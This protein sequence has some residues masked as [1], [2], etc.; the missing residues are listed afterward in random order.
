MSG[1]N[2]I[3]HSCGYSTVFQLLVRLS[4]FKDFFKDN[5]KSDQ[6]SKILNEFKFIF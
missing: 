1:I 3:G 5:S 2:N 6:G 4:K